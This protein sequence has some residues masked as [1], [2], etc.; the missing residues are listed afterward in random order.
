MQEYGRLLVSENPIRDA[1]Q[2]IEG[3]ID[4][5][6]TFDGQEEIV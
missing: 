2:T 5:V 4:A 1:K 3:Y 6:T